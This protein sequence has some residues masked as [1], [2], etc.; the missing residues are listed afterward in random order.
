M[1]YNYNQKMAILR[2]LLD[3]ISIDG[4]I[5]ER[6]TMYFERVKKEL[7][8][9]PEDHFKVKEFN[10]LLSLSILKAMSEEQKFN[11]T[12]FMKNMILI[13]GIIEPSEN[14]AYEDICGFC[15][16]PIAELSLE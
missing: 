8:L 13:D 7:N 3:I 11:Y 14:L 4:K 6:E 12:K 1:D 15:G 16:I 5:D 2:L 9:S 10:T